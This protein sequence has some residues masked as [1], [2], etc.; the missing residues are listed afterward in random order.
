M[1]EEAI[2]YSRYREHFSADQ[3]NAV[4]HHGHIIPVSRRITSRFVSTHHPGWQYNELVAVFNAAGVRVHGGGCGGYCAGGV[5][6][7]HFDDQ[8]SFAVERIDKAEVTQ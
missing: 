3:I 7:L 1:T 2:N 5:K 8:T 4:L 6:Y